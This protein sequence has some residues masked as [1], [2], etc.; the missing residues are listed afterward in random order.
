VISITRRS[1]DFQL[2]A[3]G[4]FRSPGARNAGAPGP[5]NHPHPTLSRST[6][7]GKLPRRSKKKAAR[8]LPPGRC[9]FPNS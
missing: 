3:L 1:G 5:P 8:W 9:W 7:R 2:L 4:W 6:G